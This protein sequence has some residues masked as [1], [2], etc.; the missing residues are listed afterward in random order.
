MAGVDHK[1]EHIGHI[2]IETHARLYVSHIFHAAH[3]FAPRNL[4]RVGR[5]TQGTG[6]NHKVSF[7]HF[8][9]LA[10]ENRRQGFLLFGPEFIRLCVFLDDQVV[11]HIAV[12]TGE[13]GLFQFLLQHA[14]NGNIQLSVHQQHIVPFVL[15]RF[16]KAVLLILVVGIKVNKISVLVRLVILNQCLVLFLNITFAVGIGKEGEVLGALVE[17]VL[18]KHAVIDENLQVMPFLFKLRTVVLEDG[19]QAVRYFLG[20]VCGNLLHV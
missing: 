8:G 6:R 17:I 7:L 12:H 19:L 11:Y 2:R 9:Q 10:F 15:G 16:N 20:N 14:D 18:G 4:D 3:V 13:A 5:F 1:I